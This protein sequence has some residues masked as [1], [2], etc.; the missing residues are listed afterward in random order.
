MGLKS[1]L[2]H[3][4]G[5]FRQRLYRSDKGLVLGVF[6]GIAESLGFCVFWT[7]V[8]GV[9]S[10]LGIV[11]G[12]HIFVAGFFYLLLALV[13]Q[14]PRTSGDTGRLGRDDEAAFPSP[15]VPF[16]K[17]ER[18]TSVRSYRATPPPPAR[19]DL[20]QLDRQLDGLNR[21]IQHM[22]TIVTDRQYDWDR[23]MDR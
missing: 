10:L 11:G 13:M 23:R 4:L 14:P 2:R 15:S 19:V 9:I 21:R 18:P 3:N 7:R 1:E 20:M 17:R 6:K 8:I 16:W 12:G 22:E 5:K